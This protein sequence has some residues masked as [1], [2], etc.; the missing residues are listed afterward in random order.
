M[1]SNYQIV[2]LNRGKEYPIKQRQLWIFSGAIRSFPKDFKNGDICQVRSSENEILG[3]A[4]FNNTNSLAGRML[5]FGDFD[6]FENINENIRNAIRLR[7]SIF[8]TN[9]TN[10]FRVINGESDL[11]PGLVADLYDQVLVIQVSTLGIDRIKNGLVTQI[12][13][14]LSRYIKV[15]YVFEKSKLPSRKI[16]GLKDFEALIWSADNNFNTYEFATLSEVEYTYVFKE[17]NNLFNLSPLTSHKTGFYL[18]QREMRDYVGSIAKNKKVLNCFS[19]TGGFSVYAAKAGA[20]LVSSV[21]ISKEVIEQAKKNFILN[22]I[23]VSKHIFLAQDVFKFIESENAIKD[24]DIVILDPPAFAKKK[25][26]ISAAKSGYRKL[27]RE[28]MK[29]MKSGS[30]LITCSCSYHIPY[31]MFEEIVQQSAKEAGKS[32]KILQK[33]RH[34]P[35]HPVNIYHPE[36]EYLKSLTIWID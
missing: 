11:V 6:P 15:L 27:N 17:N 29:Q 18:D 3:F 20:E 9:R 10:S 35:D 14:E 2:Y 22:N 8:D 33:H 4:Y 21:D 7:F 12:I 25:D 31:E 1:N 19:Y 23:D 30:I 32:A 36:A 13:K 26:D 34:A 24:Y 28:T 16:E 5:S